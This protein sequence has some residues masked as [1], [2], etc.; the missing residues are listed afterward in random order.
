[1]L[2]MAQ[3][4][5]DGGTMTDL[6]LRD[7]AM[8]IFLAG[9]E[10]SAN[11]LAWCW[12]LLAQHPEIET[13]FHEEVDR[14]L[15]GRPPKMDDVPQLSLTSRAFAEALR[16]YPPV[17]AVGRQAIVDVPLRRSNGAGRFRG[18]SFAIHHAT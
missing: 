13:Q 18:P 2:L 11:A 9:H 6:Q 16:L 5:D 17:W 10:T 12:Y 15:G 7:E 1:M 14:V 8:T 4:E 3:D